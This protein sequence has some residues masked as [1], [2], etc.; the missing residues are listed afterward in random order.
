M[1]QYRNDLPQL[2][3]IETTLIF[4][5]GSGAAVFRGFPSSERQGRRGC[6]AQIFSQPRFDRPAHMGM[7]FILESPTWRASPDWGAPENIHSNLDLPNFAP[8]YLTVPNEQRAQKE[9]LILSSRRPRAELAVA[10]V[11]PVVPENP[12]RGGSRLKENQGIIICDACHPPSACDG[13]RRSV[14]TAAAAGSRE[15]LSSSPA[16]HRPP[17]CTV[18]SAAACERPGVVGM[19]VTALAKPA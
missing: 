5:D 9:R 11:L 1:P 10:D 4:H 7:G 14:Q 18:P 19:D 15:S 2:N 16:Q 17:A 3:S 6:L 13:R 8:S 12:I